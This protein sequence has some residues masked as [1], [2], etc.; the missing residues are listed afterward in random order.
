MV[1]RELKDPRVP[2]VTFTS[3][4]VAQDGS[5]C[6]VLLT[7]L[8][9]D[10][11]SEENQKKMADCIEGLTSASGYIRRHLAKVLTVRYIPELRFREDK[12]LANVSRVHELLKQIKS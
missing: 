1:V 11:D 9:I 10:T 6:L 12:G 7:I 5:F 2:N 3:A 4:E 8:G